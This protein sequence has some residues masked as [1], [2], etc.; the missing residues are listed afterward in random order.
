MKLYSYNIFILADSSESLIFN[1]TP[2]RNQNRIGTKCNTPAN[3]CSMLK[4][5]QNNGT[6]TNTNTVL[7]GYLCSCPAGFSGSNCGTDIRPC[8][9]DTCWNNGTH[10]LHLIYISFFF[11]YLGNCTETSSTTFNCSCQPGWTGIHCETKINYCEKVQ[12]L[13]N[14][15]CRPLLLNFTCECLGT[16]YSGRYCEIISTQTVLRQTVSKSFSYIAIL[17]LVL[18]ASFFVIMDILKYGFGIDPAKDELERIRRQKRAQRRKP[19]PPPPVI[20]RFKYVDH[21]RSTTA[22]KRSIPTIAE[23]TI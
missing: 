21:P 13:N 7:L 23:T 17:F 15:V 6:C 8:K 5:C 4:P 18:I 12:C 10:L 20:Q 9:S 3:P 16:S 22:K 1:P 14:G 11:C 19:P 2:C